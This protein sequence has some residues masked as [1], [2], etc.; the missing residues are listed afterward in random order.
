MKYTLYSLH[1]TQITPH[2]KVRTSLLLSS[3]KSSKFR[4]QS[5]C[6]WDFV[7]LSPGGPACRH[8]AA[9]VRPASLEVAF[10]DCGSSEG[11]SSE[12]AGGTPPSR[13]TNFLASV[14]CMWFPARGCPEKETHLQEITPLCQNTRQK[15]QKPKSPPAPFYKK[16]L[17]I[18]S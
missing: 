12:S 8:E 11:P 7:P 9:F 4:L 14:E 17:N 18:I 3:E 10:S 2:I 1:C 5:P 6:L 13:G 16:F 15:S